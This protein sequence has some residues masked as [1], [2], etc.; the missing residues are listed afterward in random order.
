[1]YFVFDSAMPYWRPSNRPTDK[2]V[3]EDNSVEFE[4]QADG[5]PKPNIA[6]YINGLPVNSESIT[7]IRKMAKCKIFKILR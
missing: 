2:Q 3:D 5:H 1:M 7:D 4:C 6:W